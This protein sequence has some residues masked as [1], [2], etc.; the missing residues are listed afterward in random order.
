MATV[1]SVARYILAAAD[2]DA[3]AILAAAWVNQRYKELTSRYKFK[4]LQESASVDISGGGATFDAGVTDIQFFA[5][6]R[7]HDGTNYVRDVS[8]VTQEEL[9]DWHPDRTTANSST[10]PYVYAD[11]GLNAGAT[12]RKIEIYPTAQGNVSEA[13]TFN[14]Y[15]APA[16]LAI[17]DTLPYGIN[18]YYLSEGVLIDLYRYEQ[19]R[20]LRKGSIEAATHWGILADKQVEKW[21]RAM[22]LAYN[23]DNGITDETRYPRT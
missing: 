10:G 4:H 7:Y 11:I 19:A 1:D 18:T 22:I 16:D 12:Q 8:R 6:V 13:L 21:E 14:Y 5:R 9:D 23:A 3:N 2:T 20:A 15:E 17:S